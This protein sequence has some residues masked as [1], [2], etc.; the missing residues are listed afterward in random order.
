MANVTARH[1]N[2]TESDRRGIKDGWYATS[3]MG[4]ICSGRFSNQRIAKRRSRGSEPILMH[5]PTG[6]RL[7]NPSVASDLERSVGQRRYRAVSSEQYAQ[8]NSG[9]S[10]LLVC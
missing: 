9:H 4:K 2:E 10:W 6:R 3:P 7:Q 1:V 5:S 8:A